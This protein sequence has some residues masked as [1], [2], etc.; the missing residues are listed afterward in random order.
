M[1]FLSSIVRDL[2]KNLDS[3]ATPATSGAVGR[4]AG[5]PLRGLPYHRQSRRK[6]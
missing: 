6:A 3:L 4:G 2:A 5:M 1:I